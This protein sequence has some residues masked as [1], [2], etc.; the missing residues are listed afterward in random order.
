MSSHGRKAIQKVLKCK[1]Q[2]VCDKEAIATQYLQAR[3]D[4]YVRRMSTINEQYRETVELP[5]CPPVCPIIDG[6]VL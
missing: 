2:G 3:V 6:E 1:A 5:P 4:N